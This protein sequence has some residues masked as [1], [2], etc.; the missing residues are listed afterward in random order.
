MLVYGTKLLNTRVLS[1]QTGSTIGNVSR[2]IV[3]PDNLQIIALE[4]SGPLVSPDAYIL[5]IAS[6]REYSTYGIVIDSIDE[7][8]ASDDIIKISEIL[9]LNFNL[10]NLKVETKKGSKLGRIMDY[11]FTSEDF[12]IQQLIVKR[13]AIKSLLDP[14]LT[15]SRK[16]IV[17]VNDYKVIIE[18]EIKTIKEKSTKEEFVPNF[19]NPFREQGFAP[20]DTK[21]PDAQDN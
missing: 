5:D 3:N 17:E 20:V 1:V 10:V 2:I 18:D 11:T 8:V 21:N 16:E 13:P 14:E 12:M 9:A 7:L 4:I 19:V 6:I 15:I